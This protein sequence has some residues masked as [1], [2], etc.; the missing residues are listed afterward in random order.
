M[1]SKGTVRV[2]RNEEGW[3]VIDSA[4]TPGGCWAHFGALVMEGYHTLS[5]GEVVEFEWM[6][7]DQDGFAFRAVRVW[8][9]GVTPDDAAPEFDVAETPSDAHGSELRI[10]FDLPRSS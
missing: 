3:G 5:V 6:A 9:E 8:R 2:W 7:A 4:E 1:T 10:W